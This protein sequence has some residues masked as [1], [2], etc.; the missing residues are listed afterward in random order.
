LAANEALDK[1]ALKHP[2][3]AVAVKLRYFAGM[4]NEE[5]SQLL[6]ISLSTVKNYWNFSRIW[7]FNEIE[8]K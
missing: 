4:T 3:E 2:R 8:G 7:L 1:L 5:V 6:G